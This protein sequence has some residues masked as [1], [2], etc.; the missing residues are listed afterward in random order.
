MWLEAF[1]RDIQYG[2]RSLVKSPGFSTLAIL[3]LATG[4]MATTAIYSV[5]RAVVLDPFGGSGTVGMVANRLSRR[6]ILIDL[7]PEY[8]KQQ[9]TRNAQTPLGLGA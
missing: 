9:M 5:L 7:N 4:I 2:A 1:A 3:C 8:L 6:A